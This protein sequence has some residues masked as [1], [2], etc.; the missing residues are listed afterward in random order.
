MMPDTFQ[1]YLALP[2]EEK[3]AIM[4]Q[5]HSDRAVLNRAA[6][7]LK[8]KPDEVLYKI[9]E[10]KNKNESIRAILRNQN[11]EPCC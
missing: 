7:L 6:E 8:C 1:G 9:Q 2:V 11:I 10:L 3:K 4:L 5:H